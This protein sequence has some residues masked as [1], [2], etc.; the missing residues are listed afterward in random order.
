LRGTLQIYDM[1]NCSVALTAL[2]YVFSFIWSVNVV[3]T[4]EAL[5]IYSPEVY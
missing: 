2:R 3:L 1:Y 4:S 5:L